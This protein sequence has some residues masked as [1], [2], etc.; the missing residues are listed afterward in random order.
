MPINFLASQR[1]IAQEQAKKDGQYL[2]GSFVVLGL[3]VVGWLGCLFYT[4]TLK[5][6]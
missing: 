1:R 6:R 4:L 5:N 3:V 2:V